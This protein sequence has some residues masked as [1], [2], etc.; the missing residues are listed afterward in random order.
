[1]KKTIFTTLLL[2]ACVSPVLGAQW[3]HVRVEESHRGGETVKIN[4]PLVLLDAMMPIVEEKGFRGR[5]SRSPIRFGRHHR[6]TIE[7]LREVWEIVK[8][9]KDYELVS[10][11]SDDESIFV[12]IRGGDVLVQSRQGST[13]EMDIRVP[14]EVVDALFSGPADE[15]DF[16]AAFEVIRSIGDGEYVSI[17]DRDS[18]VRIWIDGDSGQ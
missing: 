16:V 5:S 4:I 17:K 18:T 7:E 14:I 15:L 2:I 1:M 9:E 3:L 10:V 11:D 13:S 6:W 8:N 12:M